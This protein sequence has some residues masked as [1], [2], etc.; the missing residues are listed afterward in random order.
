VEGKTMAIYTR[1]QAIDIVSV[2]AR[3]PHLIEGQL[4]L[5]VLAGDA[6]AAGALADFVDDAECCPEA[7]DGNHA[8]AV[9]LRTLVSQAP[10]PGANV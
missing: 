10:F 7:R 8:V 2:L 9:A 3:F 6:A 4:S 1:R 5:D